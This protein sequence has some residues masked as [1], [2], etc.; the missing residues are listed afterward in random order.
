MNGDDMTNEGATE[1]EGRYV[2]GPGE[3]LSQTQ[4]LDLLRDTG[5]MSVEATEGDEEEVLRELYG[6]PDEDGIY[7]GNDT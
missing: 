1:G 2:P 5:A 3:E 6:E 7:R 4:Q